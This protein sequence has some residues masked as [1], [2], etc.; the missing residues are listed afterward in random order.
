MTKSEREDYSPLGIFI[1]VCLIVLLGVQFIG[2]KEYYMDGNGEAG[3][4]SGLLSLLGI[5]FW[6][7]GL[8]LGYK[9]LKKLNNKLVGLLTII[10]SSLEFF[11]LVWAFIN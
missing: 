11:V 9:I 8:I 2:L 7:P 6:I 10:L 5:I 3:M 4:F 1:S